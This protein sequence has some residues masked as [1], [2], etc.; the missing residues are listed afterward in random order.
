M[1]NTVFDR[2]KVIKYLIWTFGLAYAIQIGVWL[3]YKN[4]L[5]LIGSLVMAAMMFVPMLGVLLSGSK[6]SGM[7]WNPRIK[8]NIKPILIA[9]FAPAVL[10]A[11]GAVLYFL[12]FPTHFD[13][14]GNYLVGA[15]G[16]EALA[17]LE[18]QGLTY[19]VYIIISA[20]SCLTYAPLLNGALA[21]GEEIGWRGFLYPQLKARFCRSIGL[22]LGG[23]IW[24]VWHAP[25]IWL[26]GYEYG[27]DYFGYPI[28]GILLFCV[29]TIAM[30]MI[31]DRLY[32]KSGS[33][34]TPS[35]CH[36]AVNA[37]ATLPLALCLS[38]TGSARLLGPVPNG[39]I[40]GIPFLAAAVIIMLRSKKADSV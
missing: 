23:V 16:E 29:F 12:I 27:T 26:I 7:G 35:I 19:P 28:V 25:L 10:T 18:A 31:C 2:T 8:K 6:L 3:L 36:G 24:G 40:A 1:N 32:E 13:M 37:A 4:G 22:L 5:S 17:Q 20:V 11:V 39:L 9:W 21:L 14:S 30:G 33:I 38:D 15:V 34:W